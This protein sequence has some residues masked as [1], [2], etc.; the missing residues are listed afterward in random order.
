M[1]TR[2]TILDESQSFVAKIIITS[3][4]PK[5]EHEF[6]K[7]RGE[8]SHPANLQELSRVLQT[9]S[10]YENRARSSKQHLFRASI[11]LSTSSQ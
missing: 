11:M 10:H 5:Q 8:F 3:F 2:G 6:H 9:Q 7:S 4:A 1:H